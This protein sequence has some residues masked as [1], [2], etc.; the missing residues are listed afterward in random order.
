[1]NRKFLNFSNTPTSARQESDADRKNWDAAV[2]CLR[3]GDHYLLV[4]WDLSADSE[5]TLRY[6]LKILAGSLGVIAFM[7]ALVVAAG[8]IEP[9]WTRLKEHVPRPNPHAL[10]AIFV[11]LTILGL[12]FQRQVGRVFGWLCDKLIFRFMEPK[13]KQGG[14]S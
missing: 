10:L 4:L 6:F 8:K 9:Q 1:M 13:D 12:L 7:L 5:W 2:R 11:G 14:E 3:R